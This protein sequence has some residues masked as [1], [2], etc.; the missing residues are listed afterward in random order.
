MKR[1]I[2]IGDLMDHAWQKAYNN[3]KQTIQDLETRL[4]CCGYAD[5]TDRSA[6][7]NCANSPAF[8]YT[9]SCKARIYD[10]L[11]YRQNATITIVTA[12]ELLQIMALTAGLVLWSKLPRENEIDSRYRDE[13]SRRILQGLSQEDERN[14]VNQN[15]GY[16]TMNS[17]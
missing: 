11:T 10:T 16:G 6:P 14:E 7:A 1:L 9:T 4:Q 2:A 12:I 8:G 15:P 5:I 3:N 17:E 13:H